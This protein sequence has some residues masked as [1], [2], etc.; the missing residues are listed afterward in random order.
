MNAP[1]WSLW[2][3]IAGDENAARVYDCLLTHGPL[4][5]TQIAQRLECPR[6][7]LYAAF[8]WLRA[9]GLVSTLVKGR[10][11]ELLAAAPSRWRAVAEQQ[12]LEAD[13]LLADIDRQM[14]E[15]V[16]SY[17]QGSRPRARAF[18]GEGG[19]KAIREEIVRFGGEVW[20]Y[21]AVDPRLKAQAKIAELER[22]QCTSE[23]PQGRVLLALPH[24]ED[25]PPFFDRRSFEA[26]WTPLA[27]AP[28]AGSLTLA[29]DRA[30][31]ISPQDGHFGLVIES[32]ETVQLLRSLFL[33]AWNQ[34]QPWQPSKG[35]GI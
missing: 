11:L 33:A 9:E 24:P 16:A 14:P 17:Q 26:R 15:W 1:R 34:A 30:Y 28:F 7:T 2:V 23:I 29:Q 5:P 4:S 35:W 20:E 6:S 21:F 32:A 3:A 19:L 27:Q 10:S 12:R 25:L 22:I 8:E 13:A 31:L 18:E